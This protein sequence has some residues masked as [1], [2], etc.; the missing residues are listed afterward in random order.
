[1]HS[2]ALVPEEKVHIVLKRTVQQMGELFTESLGGEQTLQ[3]CINIAA[4]PDIGQPATHSHVR[5][6]FMFTTRH[7]NCVNILM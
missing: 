1:M 7:E 2:I 3:T 4:V 5:Y 6:T